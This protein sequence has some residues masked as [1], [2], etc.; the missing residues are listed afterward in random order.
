MTSP[1][2]SNVDLNANRGPTIVKS[3]IAVSVVSTA[4][5]VLRFI[6][7][8]FRHVKFGADDY[9]IVVACVNLVLASPGFVD[10]SKRAI[11]LELGYLCLQY[12]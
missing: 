1:A 9:L 12:R 7:R 2:P 8:R 3:V 4:F 6:A 11:D 10:G 5:V